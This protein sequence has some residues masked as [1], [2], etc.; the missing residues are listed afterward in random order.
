MAIMR[1]KSS[2]ASSTVIIE[3]GGSLLRVVEMRATAPN[4]PAEI[5][6]YSLPWRKQAGSI[7]SEAGRAE[8]TEAFKSIA[9]RERLV[10]TRVRIAL[11]GDFCVTR[12]VTGPT[13][14]VK[15]E[16]KDLGERSQLYLSLGPGRKALAGSVHQ[17]DARHQHALLSIANQHTLDAIFQAAASVGLNLDTVEPSLVALSRLIGEMQF[18]QSAPV[19]AA[20][21]GERGV[22]LGISYRGQLLLDYR[23]G[24]RSVHEELPGIISQHLPR[25]RRYC[26]RYFRHAEGELAKIYICG[27]AT[28]TQGL[29]EGFLATGRLQVAALDLQQLATHW[30]FREGTPPSDFAAALGAAL[31]ASSSTDQASPNLMEE[32]TRHVGPP[33]VPLL[34]RNFWPVAAVLLLSLLGW[35]GVARESY[36]VSRL[37]ADLSQYEPAAAE[38]RE[39]RLTLSSFETQGEHLT[40]LEQGL[41]EPTWHQ[42]L[43]LISGS[44]PDEIWLDTL[45]LDRNGMLNMSGGSFRRDAI[46]EF[47]AWLGRTGAFADV[48][49]VSTRPGRWQGR[50]IVKFDIHGTLIEQKAVSP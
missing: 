43:K 49:L 7:H 21:V 15:R 26:R 22:E 2:A 16:L 3:V 10:G 32:M 8:L 39:L 13:D 40:R 14:H 30:R 50:E 20:Y 47:V 17:I 46:H 28:A 12:V 11:N 33:L 38:A 42:L 18:D 25:L 19:L 9:A 29:R 31:G 34:A 36:V 45:R 5:R 44:M 1:N 27:P 37:K 35:L 4:R 6:T 48:S 23:P 24:G 41:A